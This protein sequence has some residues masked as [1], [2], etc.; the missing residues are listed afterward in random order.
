MGVG[1]INS[2]NAL[3]LPKYRIQPKDMSF[4]YQIEPIK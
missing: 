4:T 1:G 3:P 2:W